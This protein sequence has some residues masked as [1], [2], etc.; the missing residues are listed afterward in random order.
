MHDRYI[1]DPVLFAGTM[2]DNLDPFNEHADD[3]L[4]QTL[5]YV[6]L[7]AAVSSLRSH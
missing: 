3:E 2:R 1:Q 5:D 6:Q 7:K 4:W